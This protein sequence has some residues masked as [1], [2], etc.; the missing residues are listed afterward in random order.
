MGRQAA[1]NILRRIG[2]AATVPFRY[3]NYGNLATIGR[4]SA[5]VDLPTPLGAIRFSGYPAWLFWLFAHVWFLIGFRNR[6][7][8]LLDWAAAY[9]SRQRYARVVAGI[10][11]A[12]APDG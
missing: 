9:W 1:A 12:A 7:V 2:N 5:V 8:V 6:L 11:P 10:E 4:H 3:R